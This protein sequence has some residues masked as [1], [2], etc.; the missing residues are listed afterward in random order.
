MFQW[1]RDAEVCY[2]FLSDVD[3]DEN[4]REGRSFRDPRWFTRGWTLQELIAPGVVYF[5]G[6]GWKPMGSRDDLL[7][8]IVSITNISA[9]YFKDGNLSGFSAAQKLSWAAR[10]RT[11]RLE[12]EAYCLLGLFDINMPLLYG[13]GTRAFQR[14]Q[15]EILRQSEDDS[16]FAHSH[17][18]IMAP[19]PE[20]FWP[21]APICCLDEPWLYR[22][23]PAFFL[24]RNL[25]LN[26][27]HITMSFPA[28]RMTETEKVRD[29][30]FADQWHTEPPPPGGLLL[31]LLNCGTD[32]G[33]RR[34]LVLVDQAPLA[35][36]K[37]PWLTSPRMRAALEPALRQRVE[38]VTV[39]IAREKA[40]REEWE[41]RGRAVP[42]AALSGSPIAYPWQT[43]FDQWNRN[44]MTPVARLAGWAARS[45][46]ALQ[47]GFRD[48]VV[49]KGPGQASGFEAR[50]VHTARMS[51]N[52]LEW[53]DEVHMIGKYTGSQGQPFVIFSS[54]GGRSFMVRLSPTRASVNA[55]LY[56]DI[57]PWQGE[58][59]FSYCRDLEMDRKKNAGESPCHRALQRVG[60]KGRVVVELRSR[61]RNNG[62]WVYVSVAQPPKE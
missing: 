26:R 29:L 41:W 51:L 44:G 45:Q 58:R 35:W 31:A 43:D 61:R 55:N 13:E 39:S 4:P 36:T 40:A 62:W 34:V 18:D 22:D 33:S 21:C 27:A 60:K 2:A 37:L 6:A 49:V 47:D 59:D 8:V 9:S 7:D 11:T 3:A 54:V 1:Y 24:N 20:S 19:S 17:G 38:V 56:T 16:L 10:R 32:P 46:L 53:G 48:K 5:H 42:L 12:D 52:W 57:P 14:L 23:H 15:E 50:H 28:V 25:S 30:C